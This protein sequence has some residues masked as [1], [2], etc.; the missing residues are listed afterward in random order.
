M[1]T[2]T[3]SKCG[4]CG[5]PLAAEFEGQTISCPMC[6]TVNE[7]TISQGII[8]S[9]PVFVGILAFLGGMLL[10]PAI[11]ASTSGGRDWLEKQAREAIRR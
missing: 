9:T 5:Y 2:K 3:I 7:A 1:A 6:G 11:I 10:G 8:I 4:V